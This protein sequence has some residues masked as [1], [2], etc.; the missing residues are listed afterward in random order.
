MK[1][2][3]VWAIALIIMGLGTACHR[4]RS[5]IVVKNEDGE[6]E[7]TY[8]G[9][10]RFNDAET[11]IE[12]ISPGGYLNYRHNDEM[13]TAGADDRGVMGYDLFKD[14]NPVDT[15]SEIGRAQLTRAVHSMIALGFDAGGRLERLY[16]K[17]GYR[18]LLTAMDSVDGDYVKGLYIERI[19]NTDSL[20]P[21]EM[22]GLVSRIG[23]TLGSDY[24]KQRLLERV[25][26]PYLKNDS[27]AGCYLD[28]VMTI[29]GDYE[30]SQAM[31]H[32]L[33]G[34]VT[35]TR[36]VKALEVV[37]KISGDYEKSNLLVDIAQRLPK[38][39]SLKALYT[40]A[41]KTVHSDPDYG[42]VMRALQ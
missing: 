41:A 5:H 30:K 7:M 22:A 3:C 38:T 34:P 24:D 2:Y 29:G 42:R 11:A 8:R 9:E 4:H 32:F 17:G 35:D 12:S 20:K 31:D 36:W 27:V 23:R 15:A 6:T 10:I 16:R 26:S 21:D 28:A 18:A 39:D 13:L 37:G 25:D 14:G 19:M 33:R 40:T 1:K